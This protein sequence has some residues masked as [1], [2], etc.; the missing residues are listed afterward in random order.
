MEL[1]NKIIGV[2]NK[3]YNANKEKVLHSLKIKE[4]D[5]FKQYKRSRKYKKEIEL[6]KKINSNYDLIKLNIWNDIYRDKKEL[7]L[8]EP[9]LILDYNEQVELIKLL[10]SLKMKFDI[11]FKI[12][13][14]DT[15]FLISLVDYVFIKNRGI[16]IAQGSKYEILGNE[17][18]LLENNIKIPDII[19][20]KNYVY[21]R[22]GI[23]LTNRD[24][25]NDLIKD[26]YMV[27]NK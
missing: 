6:D 13:S 15:D 11:Q 22:I 10:K 18:L 4:N 2:I 26:I 19:S 27:C 21:K 7:T 24:N 25:V 16:I 17:K 3:K 12:V 14:N 5:K 9:S 1:N 8:I 23:K 20:F